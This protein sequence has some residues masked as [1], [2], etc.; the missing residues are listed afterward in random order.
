MSF[1]SRWK[2]LFSQH[3]NVHTIIHRMGVDIGEDCAL[4]RHCKI[5]GAN[6]RVVHIGDRARIA[7]CAI[8]FAHDY[9]GG[10]MHLDTYIGKQSIIGYASI[11]LPGVKVGDNVIVAAGSV[12]SKDVP[13]N[14]IVAG[15]PAKII[16]EGIETNE[17]GII[18]NHG[19]KPT[20]APMRGGKFVIHTINTSLLPCV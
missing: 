11:F 9:Y 6:P 1:V 7:A 12:V 16:K 18:A 13:D 2:Y 4:H 15:N 20:V 14:C 17:H 3:P 10:R 19:N 8:I 5:D